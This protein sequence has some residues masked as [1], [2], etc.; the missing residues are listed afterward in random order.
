MAE[1]FIHRRDGAVARITLD[2][3]ENGNALSLSRATRLGT[4]ISDYAA[5]E[6]VRAIL[7]R[8]AGAHFCRG[9]DR[10]DDPKGEFDTLHE[11]RAA[12]ADPVLGLFNAVR[13]TP[14]PVVA[15]VTGLANGLGCALASAC[16]VTIAAEDAQ[17]GIPAMDRGR[18]PTLAMSG[19]FDRVPPKALQWMVYTCRKLDARAAAAIGLVSHVVPAAAFDA[20]IERTLA[21]M[22][23]AGRGAL[24]AVKKYIRESRLLDLRA[25]AELGG[26]IQGRFELGLGD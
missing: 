6:S 5:D 21:E 14:V 11:W 18:P 9:R 26:N 4:L 8:G 13:D 25:A 17:F 10:G 19:A 12:L 1:D 22:T 7:L 3:P 15:A 23:R 16:D 20:E 2:M 24:I